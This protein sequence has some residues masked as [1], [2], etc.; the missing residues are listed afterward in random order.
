[1]KTARILTVFLLVWWS[2]GR[3]QQISGSYYALWQYYQT[4]TLLHF[5]APEGAFRSMHYLD[6]HG[7]S[8]DW[9][10]GL[11]A[12]YYLP[13]ALIGFN[14]GLKKHFLGWYVRYAHDA[15]DLRAGTVY[16][17]TGSGSVFRTWNDKQLGLDNALR[18]VDLQ[19]RPDENTRLKLIAGNMRTGIDYAESFIGALNFNREFSFDRLRLRFDATALTRY[20]A[21][22]NDAVPANVNL[23]GL[24]TG[25]SYGPW[26]LSFEY[27]YK[28]PDAL[29]ANGV[30]NDRVL[31]DGDAYTFNAGYARKGL[32]INLTLRRAE[33]LQMYARRDLQ[34][35]PYNVGTV[36]YVP[37]L[38]KQHDY[39]LATIYVYSVR[40]GISF[41][42][43]TVGEIGGQADAVFKLR[44]KTPLGG[45]YGTIVSVNASQWHALNAEFFPQRGIYRRN[46]WQAGPL[47]YRD[48]NLEV[49]RKLS[50]RW[51]TAFFVM[52][53]TYNQRLLEGHGQMVRAL[54][55]VTDWTYR[56]H[57]ATSLRL[58]LEHLWSGQDERN[59]AAGGLEFNLRGRYG[60][61]LTDMYNYGSTGIHYYNA[62]FVYTQGGNR[63]QLGYGR[64]RGGL[65]CVGGVCRYVP[66]NKGLQL[67]VSLSLF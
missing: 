29:Y 52:H 65:V 1:M 17:Q 37:A 56:I 2:T 67:S 4:D 36:N 54:T 40:Q 35:N 62:G 3:A 60:F 58:E 43:G 18:G 38:I 22:E 31:F 41:A 21:P 63:L 34:G 11:S 44:R 20:Y 51:K 45:R 53:Q 10:A 8:G 12:E 14:P 9:E 33:N 28:T 16:D 27:D 46:F 61:F 25:L 7:G 50:R 6:L 55:A 66:P 49:K 15:W 5:R 57:G 48:I 23:Y 59:W 24:Q 42:D 64:Q 19:Y 32:G 39:P 47:Y 26:D 13:Q 30:L